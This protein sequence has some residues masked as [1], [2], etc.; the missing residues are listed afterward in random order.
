MRQPT[1]RAA[2]ERDHERLGDQLAGEPEARRAEGRAD[3]ELVGVTILREQQ[4]GDIDAGNRQ[5]NAT[6]P[7]SAC[8]GRNCATPIVHRRGR[9]VAAVRFRAP[10]RE[11]ARQRVSSAFAAAIVTPGRRRATA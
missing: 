8:V 2:G 9:G 7:S 1:R 6:A 4:V 5:H 11:I 10:L 3:G